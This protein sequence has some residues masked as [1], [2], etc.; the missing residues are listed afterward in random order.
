MHNSCLHIRLSPTEP[1]E[2]GDRN[3]Q[4]GACRLNVSPTG[5]HL[6]LPTPLLRP[7]KRLSC[8][9]CRRGRRSPCVAP[10]PSHVRASV[11]T[12]LRR[13]KSGRPYA[14][15]RRHRA[16]SSELKDWSFVEL[17][18]LIA[19]P[20]CRQPEDGEAERGGGRQLGTVRQLDSRAA[21]ESFGRWLRCS[22]FRL[23]RSDAENR[24]PI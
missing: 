13:H 16:W 5:S 15:P 21:V 4:I 11:V 3:R 20:S 22:I 24:S 17:W 10:P 12:G 8:L 9:H 14:R 18:S 6:H 7:L 2:I 19:P 23:D 1:T